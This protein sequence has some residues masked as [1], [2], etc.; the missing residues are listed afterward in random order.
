MEIKIRLPKKMGRGRPTKA[1]IEL[2][3][4]LLKNFADDMIAIQKTLDFHMSARG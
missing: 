1:I 3:Y 2:Q 4:D